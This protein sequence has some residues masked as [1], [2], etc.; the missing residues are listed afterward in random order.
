MEYIKPYLSCAQQADKLI[1][2]GLI[3]DRAD[4]EQKLRSV[5]YYRLSAYWHPFRH[6]TTDAEGNTIHSFPNTSFELIWNHYLF[7]RKLRLLFMD[8]IERIEVALRSRLVDY[9]T[10][11][12]SPFDYILEP[13]SG[14]RLAT[15]EMQA[16]IIDGECNFRNCKYTCVRHFFTKYGDKHKHLPFWMFAEIADFGFMALFY[17]GASSHIQKCVAN[18]WGI[19]VPTL[20]SWLGSINTLRNTC[21]HHARTW[22]K[23]WG[24]KPKLPNW[25]EK[26]QRAWYCQYCEEK[27]LWVNSSSSTARPS[28]DQTKTAA[29]L[30]ICRYLMRRIAPKSS[31]HKRV[32]ALF[33]A[34]KE[35]GINFRTMGLPN[36]WQRHPLWRSAAAPRR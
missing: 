20:I 34:F 4:M 26:H 29:L 9:Y 19:T 3:G 25:S 13:P 24:L 8:A 27:Q 23:A 6:T 1:R 35:S 33:E 30:F 17:K 18:E 7:D 28:I 5:S 14:A 31:W 11:K 12:H 36:H 16:G 22:N 2:Q 15:L 21:A 10:Q 32:E